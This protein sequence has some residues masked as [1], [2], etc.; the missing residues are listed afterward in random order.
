MHKFKHYLPCGHCRRPVGAE[1]VALFLCFSYLLYYSEKIARLYG[2][3]HPMGL[4]VHQPNLLRVNSYMV[5]SSI[6]Q[7]YLVLKTN[8]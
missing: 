6:Y 2:P 7:L 1:S 5:G 8:S 4:T 3:P